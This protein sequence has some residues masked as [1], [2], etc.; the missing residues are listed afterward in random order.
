MMINYSE[1]TMTHRFSVG[2][3]GKPPT[4]TTYSQYPSVPFKD[5]GDPKT[6]QFPS[7]ESS[8]GQRCNFK[9]AN[10][11]NTISVLAPGSPWMPK[12]TCCDIVGE[13]RGRYTSQKRGNMHEKNWKLFL[14]G[15]WTLKIA[16][17]QEFEILKILYISY[18]QFKFDID[19]EHEWDTTEKM[20]ILEDTNETEIEILHVWYWCKW[21]HGYF[22]RAFLPTIATSGMSS[23]N[24]SPNHWCVNPCTRNRGTFPASGFSYWKNLTEP[25]MSCWNFRSSLRIRKGCHGVSKPS[26]LRSQGCHYEGL[27]IGGVRGQ[28]S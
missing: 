16:T 28:D 9:P 8:W 4:S 23:P 3:A 24:R 27:V 20:M 2:L 7:A 21:H 18:V 15:T 19:R 13:F 6:L 5:K 12:P 17:K 1:D 10:N 26:V 25:S 11:P 22:L 14:L